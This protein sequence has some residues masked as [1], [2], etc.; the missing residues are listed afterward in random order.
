MNKKTD[1]TAQILITKEKLE[2]NE[3]ISTYSFMWDEKNVLGLSDLFTEKCVWSWYRVDGTAVLE[4]SGR[5]AF[6]DF[7]KQ[8]FSNELKGIQTRHFQTN[9]IF[10][11]ITEI[12]AK[13]K[14]IYFSTK[15]MLNGKVD[16]ENQPLTSYQGVYEDEF[17]KTENGWK[18]KNRKVVTDN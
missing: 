4:I 18:F 5:E 6:N 17:V 12:T 16:M 13:T 7:V 15:V 9:T 2:I 11:E 3:L 1:N 10:I 8:L 14:T